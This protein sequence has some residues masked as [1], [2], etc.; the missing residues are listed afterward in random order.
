MAAVV[1]CGLAAPVVALGLDLPHLDDA[2]Q[3]GRLYT[4]A[5]AGP[6]AG[7]WLELLGGVLLAGCGGGLLAG[8]SR[9]GA[10][11]VAA[12]TR[13]AHRGDGADAGAPLRDG[14]DA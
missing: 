5:S 3:V 9:T 8:A 4:D 13:T 7:L 6:E 14:P 11:T 2:G 12:R 1:G 10:R